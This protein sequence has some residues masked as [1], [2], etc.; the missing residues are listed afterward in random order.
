MRTSF[1]LRRT[2]LAASITLLVRPIGTWAQDGAVDPSF[3][4]ST[5]GTVHCIVRQ[6]DGKLL[7]GG[8]FTEVNGTGRGM[9]A[10]LHADGGLDEG[11]D[12]GAGF[13]GQYGMVSALALTADGKVLVGGTF[14]DYDGTAVNH[15]ARLNGDG[16]LDD[17]FTTGTGP[18]YGVR[19]LAVTT[20]GQIWVGGGFSEYDGTSASNIVRLN[21]SGTVDTAFQPVGGFGAQPG[22]SGSAVHDLMVRPDGSLLAVG[23]FGT[24]NGDTHRNI[25][26]FLADGTVDPGF[27]TG[28]GAYGGYHVRLDKVASAPDGKA[29]IVGDFT[30]YDEVFRSRM[31]RLNADGSLDT[32]F[33]PGTGPTQG[34]VIAG[35]IPI[36][37]AAVRPDGR[38]LIGG[39]FNRIVDTPIQR[40]ARI[41]PTGALDPTFDPG[42][43][44]ATTDLLNLSEVLAIAQ[45]PDG[46]LIVGGSFATFD[47][48]PH[49]NLVRVRSNTGTGID[50]RTGPEL[51]LTSDAAMLIVRSDV[52]PARLQLLDAMGRTLRETARTTELPIADL[53]TATY[54]LR[55][56][57]ADGGQ[58]AVKWVKGW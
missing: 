49:A 44:P 41:L 35:P 2:L 56:Q 8:T 30:Y 47:G 1:L 36:T 23:S 38:L 13:T 22:S 45:L 50:T 28:S 14:T 33:D 18:S 42:A 17:T 43:G 16:T 7:I 9:V 40:L 21:A 27:N 34:P 55:I 4:A 19:A 57:W 12:T 15:L 10:R 5:N 6:P 39:W 11:F 37:C 29:Y 52:P 51:H 54:V 20:D 24:F 53:A 3:T 25:I 32:T 58:Q 31:A 46:D 48:A 26:Q